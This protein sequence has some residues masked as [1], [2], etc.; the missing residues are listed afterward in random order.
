[1]YKKVTIGIIAR[2]NSTADGR[3]EVYFA[4]T[5]SFCWNSEKQS[6]NSAIRETIQY[7]NSAKWKTVEKR[8]RRINLI[9]KPRNFICLIPIFQFPR[10]FTWPHRWW[11]SFHPLSLF[12]HPLNVINF[13]S[14]YCYSHVRCQGELLF[15]S[16]S[17]IL[18][19]WDLARPCT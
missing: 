10:P 14:I 5:N 1:M 16:T 3:T 6:H 13:S 17:L 7:S 4:K 8:N 11:I 19:N 2:H 12:P 9:T 18:P 15:G